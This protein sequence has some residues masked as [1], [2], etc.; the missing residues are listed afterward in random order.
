MAGRLAPAS[1][2]AGGHSIPNSAK[3]K[4]MAF[5]VK[6]WLFTGYLVALQVWNFK[7]KQKSNQLTLELT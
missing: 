3:Y 6:F 4:Y 5:L 7:S 2:V 1:D